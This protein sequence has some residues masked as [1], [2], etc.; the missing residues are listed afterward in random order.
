[1]R[2]YV[3]CCT[4]LIRRIRGS[5][6]AVLRHRCIEVGEGRASGGRWHVMVGGLRGGVGLI[7]VVY[8]TFLVN[9]VVVS[10]SDV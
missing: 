3:G 6:C 1:M 5:V 10:I 2:T 4:G 9:Y 7:N 8:S